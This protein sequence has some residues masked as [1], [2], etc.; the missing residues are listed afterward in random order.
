MD[1]FF[2]KSHEQLFLSTQILAIHLS[3]EL[4]WE[5][6]E[7]IAFSLFVTLPVLKQSQRTARR[8]PLIQVRIILKHFKP[9]GK[10]TKPSQIF[11]P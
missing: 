9:T 11:P 1:F 6:G 10:K 2:P 5:K 8:S 3:R 7:M 4:K